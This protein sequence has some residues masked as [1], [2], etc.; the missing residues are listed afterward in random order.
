MIIGLAIILFVSAGI[1]VF[2]GNDLRL[3][4][5]FKNSRVGRSRNMNDKIINQK[6]I[7]IENITLSREQELVFE[8]LESTENNYFITGKAGTGKSLLLEYFKLKSNKKLIVVAPTGVA[9]INVGGQTIHS[10]FRIAPGFVDL[11][12]L[13]L[14][15]KVAQLLKNIDTLVIDEISM[16]RADLMDAID[17]LLK[18]ARKSKLPFGGVQM[19]LFGDL[20]QLPPIVDDPELYRYFAD[21]HGGYY[22]FNA[23]VWNEADLEIIELSHIFNSVRN[24]LSEETLMVELNKRADVYIPADGSVTLATT[25][26]SVNE[27][28][29]KK[30]AELPGVARKSRATIWG[31]F[32]KSSFPTEEALKLKKG[33][34]VMLLRN[35]RE[36]RWVNGTLGIIHSLSDDEVKIDID[37]KVYSVSPETWNKISYYYNREKGRVEEEVVSSFTQLPLRLAWAITI[38]KSQGQTYDSVIIDMGR[39][40]FSH[41]QT[42]VALSRCTTLDGLYLK[43]ALTRRDIIVDNSVI[44]FMQKASVVKIEK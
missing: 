4:A 23:H 22:F 36:K 21:N 7:D 40:A 28:N 19:V 31:N 43:R 12:N 5:F 15:D 17:Y 34:Q 37:G 38:H 30:L 8:K 33:A 18:K 16:V 41:G 3:P 20:Y 24:G 29:E 10:L 26:K 25:N 2:F 44:T 11:H 39:G 42:Y 27:I 14:D 32:E 35:D 13:E 1:K 6:A 9:A